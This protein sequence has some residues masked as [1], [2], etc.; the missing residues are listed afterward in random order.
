MHPQRLT[1]LLAFLLV[2]CSGEEIS[3][4]TAPT[5]AEA[6]PD[7]EGTSWQLVDIRD[8]FDN[9]YAPGNPEKYILRFRGEGR[10][11]VDADCNQAGA[12]WQQQEGLL[13]FSDLFT[14]RA[15]CPPPSLFNRYIMSLENVASFAMR[16]SNLV[17]STDT[18]DTTLEFE[19]YVFNPLQ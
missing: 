13:S 2:A 7:L 10:L 6:I 1:L 15:L 12:S 5:A 9:V 11:Q 17:L 8:G 14:T 18:Y 19:P 4:T 16:D 3:Q